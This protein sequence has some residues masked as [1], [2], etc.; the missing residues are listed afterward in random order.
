MSL[1]TYILLGYI[2]WK[3]LAACKRKRKPDPT[4][5]GRLVPRQHTFQ[6]PPYQRKAREWILQREHERDR[7]DAYQTACY[8]AHI[9]CCAR[10]SQHQFL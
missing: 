10:K 2:A 3:L 1:C 8:R 6:S 7:I 4:L 5:G 9:A